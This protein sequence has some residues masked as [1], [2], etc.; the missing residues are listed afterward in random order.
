MLVLNLRESKRVER[1]VSHN[2]RIVLILGSGPN[3]P[4]AATWAA[5]SF[6][7]IVAINNA[8]RVRPDWNHLIFPED[9]PESRRPA[10]I[11]PAQNLVCADAF[12]PAQNA[13]GGFV[14]A[15]GT[16][17]FTAGYWALHALRPQVIAWMGCDMVYPGKGATHFYGTGAADPL[18]A[19]VTLQD[20][21]AKSARLALLAARQGCLCVN[22]SDAPSRLRF[23]RVR[24]DTLR[25]LQLNLPDTAAVGGILRHEAELDY[26]VPSGRYW[27]E[28]ERFD[29]RALSALDTRW[30]AAYEPAECLSDPAAA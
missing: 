5:G 1:A 20:L 24:V 13:Y 16:M 14:F 28:A 15:G 9:F 12:V 10:V 22:L 7:D 11:D 25:S 18:R 29:A 17:A 30:R 21:E 3:V 27:E 23:P 19:D 2:S 6:D 4:K 8:W 26:Q